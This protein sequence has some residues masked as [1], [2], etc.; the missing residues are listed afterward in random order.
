M[1]RG[2]LFLIILAALVFFA[3]QVVLKP[4]SGAK[5]KAA[6]KKAK[7]EASQAV[8]TVKKGGKR[9]GKLKKQTKE[10]KKAEKDRSRAERRKIKQELRRRKQEERSA[11]K[12]AKSKRGKKSKKRIGAYVLQAIVWFDVGPSYAM[13]DG[14][15]YELGDVVSGRKIVAI[16]QD[17]IVVDYRGAQT[18]VR[19]GESVLPKGYFETGRRSRK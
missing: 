4:K 1:R 12:A 19:M 15:K 13:V 5:V 6:V 14:R 11:R 10:E 2:I 9:A 8:G 7:T 17:Q 18:V 16:K 3:W